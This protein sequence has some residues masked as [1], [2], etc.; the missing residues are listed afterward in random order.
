MENTAEMQPAYRRTRIVL[1]ISSL[2]ARPSASLVE[3]ALRYSS[4]GCN[5]YVHKKG[6]DGTKY[7][8]KNILMHNKKKYLNMISIIYVMGLVAKKGDKLEFMASGGLAKTA[9]KEIHDLSQTFKEE[10]PENFLDSYF[11]KV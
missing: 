2:H 10:R 3:L 6:M 4:Q 9:L 7:P 5:L 1:K 11:R 8:E